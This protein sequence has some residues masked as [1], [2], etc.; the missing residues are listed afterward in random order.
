M[1][2]EVCI[3]TGNQNKVREFK[4]MLEPLGFEVKCAKDYGL[5]V[6]CEETGSTFEENSLIKAQYI[7]SKL[8]DKIIIA[9]DSGLS[10]DALD[11]FPGIYSARFM[12]GSPYVDKCNAII[13]KL[14][15]KN[16]RSAH[17]NSA[18]T[19][20]NFEKEP[21]TFVGK[22]YGK[23][24]TE[25]HGTNGFGYDPIFI[26]DDLH[27]AFGECTKDEKN[28]VSH[29]SRALHQLLEYIKSNM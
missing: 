29:R 9:D 15:D 12:E 20:V 25:I 7:A 22:T 17:F 28:S 18:I 8:K 10:I 16:D 26:S 24:A 19:I 4:E 3:A 21:K 11:G 6:D 2:K 27:K 1:I 14:K 23:I 5:A 13:E